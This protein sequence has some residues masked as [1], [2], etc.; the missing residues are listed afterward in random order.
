MLKKKGQNSSPEQN[1]VRT[2][3]RVCLRVCTCACV[4]ARACIHVRAHMPCVHMRARM[5]VCVC[6]RVCVWVFASFSPTYNTC[7]N[8]FPGTRQA[9]R[10]L[11]QHVG[12]LFMFAW[13]WNMLLTY[14]NVRDLNIHERLYEY[15]SVRMPGCMSTVMQWTTSSCPCI[16][17]NAT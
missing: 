12:G 14:H 15:L 7:Y 8:M 2:C 17:C 9:P 16:I 6:V 13:V 3:V 1:C 10:P 4:H 11:S 5:R